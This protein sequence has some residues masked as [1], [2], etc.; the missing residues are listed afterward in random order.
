MVIFKGNKLA[1]DSH[2]SLAPIART[3]AMMI[4]I[5]DK[6]GSCKKKKKKKFKI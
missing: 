1:N 4:M 5:I 2:E 3:F 6:Q